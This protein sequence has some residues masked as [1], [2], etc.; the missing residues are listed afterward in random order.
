MW[1][2]KQQH[3][4]E[5]LCIEFLA[6][7]VVWS[8]YHQAGRTIKETIGKNSWF[9]N[10]VMPV[11]LWTPQSGKKVVFCDSDDDS[12]SDSDKDSANAGSASDD[13]NWK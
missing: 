7:F 10:K 11:L 6:D 4:N 1:Y 3:Y 13:N 2:R 9:K 8:R 5:G 12:D